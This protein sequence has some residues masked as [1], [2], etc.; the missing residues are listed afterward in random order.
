MLAYQVGV[1]VLDRQNA[2]GDVLV[3]HDAVD[4]RLAAR[5]DHPVLAHGDPGVLVYPPRRDGSPGVSRLLRRHG[6]L[7]STRPPASIPSCYLNT[8]SGGVNPWS[9]AP[10]GPQSGI[11]RAGRKITQDRGLT[12]LAGA[13]GA[14]HTRSC[15]PSPLTSAPGSLPFWGW[16]LSHRGDLGRGAPG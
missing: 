16:Y 15:R 3:V 7:R 4:A 5:T 2:N 6:P 12:N 14:R 11:R 13:H 9:E 10:V 1:S 8:V